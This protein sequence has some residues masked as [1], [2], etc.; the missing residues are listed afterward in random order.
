MQ[1]QINTQKYLEYILDITKKILAV[2]SP[3]GFTKRAAD[4]VMEEY[5]ALG[6]APTQTVKGG[7][8]CEIDSNAQ[9]GR[10][11]CRERV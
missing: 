8:L 4:Y 11:S 9:I 3:S 5:A 2:D 7:V 1:K 10:A 6:Y